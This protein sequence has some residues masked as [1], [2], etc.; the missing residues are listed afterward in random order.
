[1]EGGRQR[2]IKQRGRAKEQRQK[3]QKTEAWN[4]R[5]MDNEVHNNRM[6]AACL[7]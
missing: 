2:V 3:K 6:A 1:M 4:K 5:W 7:M